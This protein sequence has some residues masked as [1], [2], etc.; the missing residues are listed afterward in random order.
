MIE[1]DVSAPDGRVLHVY[2]S[3]YATP[4]GTVYWQHG[5]G[6]CGLPPAPL[7]DRADE[8][9]LRVL[10]HDRPGYGGSSARPGR[11]VADGA[12]DLVTVLDQLGV[13]SATTIGLSAGAMH[14]LGAVAR[15]P[16]RFTAA[17]VLGG[18]APFGAA[19]LDWFAGMA[20][21]NRA[22]FEAALLGRDA[23]AAHLASDAAVDLSMFAPEDLQAMHGPYW[24]WQL[25]AAGTASPEGSIEDELACLADWGFSLNDIAVPVLV[26]HGAGDTFV[27]AGHAAWVAEAIPAAVLRLEHGGH[28]STIPRVED[29][30]VWLR[31]QGDSGRVRV[32]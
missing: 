26:L 31:A 19:G 24:D 3:G 16:S 15:H 6:M 11:S 32:R 4:E 1:R 5:A 10:G 27:P 29:A 12:S 8:L 21:P 23:L 20:E 28:I 25:D 7:V 17:A 30:L 18:P 13:E 9:G 2:D 22:E 14:A